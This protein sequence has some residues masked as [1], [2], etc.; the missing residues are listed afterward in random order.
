MAAE[1]ELGNQSR[2][3]VSPPQLHTHSN[4]GTPTIHSHALHISLIHR[5]TASY[6]H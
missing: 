3:T 5:M 1:L 6:R 2:D 4:G